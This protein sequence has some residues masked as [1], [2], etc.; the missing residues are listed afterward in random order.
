MEKRIKNSLQDFLSS[1][2]YFFYFSTI[3]LITFLSYGAFGDGNL[4]IGLGNC[5]HSIRVGGFI[6]L[7]K[8]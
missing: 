4:G 3:S 5:L 6:V 8:K 2:R 7:V 1:V